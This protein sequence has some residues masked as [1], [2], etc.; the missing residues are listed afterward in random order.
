VY[1]SKSRPDKLL[2]SAA[3]EVRGL[4]RRFNDTMMAFVRII[5]NSLELRCPLGS[6]LWARVAEAHA[7]CQILETGT[8]KFEIK[9]SNPVFF[10]DIYL[11]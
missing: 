8:W 11:E 3:C 10:E 1:A 5:I 7:R 9:E 6:Q 4:P 2:K